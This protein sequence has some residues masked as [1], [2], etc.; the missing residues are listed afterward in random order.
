[1][2]HPQHA[3]CP[4]C[5]GDLGWAKQDTVLINGARFTVRM[6]QC[7]DCSEMVGPVAYFPWAGVTI[8]E[9]PTWFGP[10]AA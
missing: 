1:M 8:E 5:S 10:G 9:A 6:Q 4:E 3:S 7:L 2:S